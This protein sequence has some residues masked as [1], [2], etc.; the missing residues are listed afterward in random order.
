MAE[1]KYA[2]LYHEVITDPRFTAMPDATLGRYARML[3]LADLMWPV[4][5]E[6]TR[7]NPSTRYLIGA[8]LVVPVEGGRRYTIRGLDAMRERRAEA[9]RRANRVR[10][11]LQAESEPDSIRTPTQ[12]NTTQ[13]NGTGVRNASRG[14]VHD[15]RHGRSC[16]VC[17][18]LLEEVDRAQEG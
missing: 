10:W 7:S 5:P 11:G 1:G 6:L 9:A 12:H 8:G 14:G 13:P 4:P 15:G 17:A 16:L 3:L 2:R 18:A